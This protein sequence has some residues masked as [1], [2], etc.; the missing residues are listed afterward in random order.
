MAIHF[1]HARNSFISK[2]NIV[3]YEQFGFLASPPP[4]PP[5]RIRL[6]NWLAFHQVV[7]SLPREEQQRACMYYIF[8]LFFFLPG[9]QGGNANSP[10]HT[11]IL[12]SQ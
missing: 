1:K 3:V 12:S 10:R 8:I 6:K 2:Q 5:P 9:A 4:P 11:Y 7:H